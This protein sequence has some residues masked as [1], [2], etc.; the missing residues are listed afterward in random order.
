MIKSFEC[1]N[2]LRCVANIFPVIHYRP[3]TILAGHC[4]HHS[5][6]KKKNSLFSP[7]DL[8]FH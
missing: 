2:L 4:H 1:F 3:F 8:F 7:F 6:P 5:K